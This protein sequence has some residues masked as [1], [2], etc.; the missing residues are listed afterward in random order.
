M[1]KNAHSVISYEQKIAIKCVKSA[2]Y[3]S[4]VSSHSLKQ[5][6]TLLLW[7]TRT[8]AIISTVLV[9][10]WICV[11]MKKKEMQATGDGEKVNMM[12]KDN[13]FLMVSALVTSHV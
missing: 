13:K 7:F 9:F 8:V 10:A 5:L 1:F 11:H 4:V 3:S 12:K 2:H 6:V